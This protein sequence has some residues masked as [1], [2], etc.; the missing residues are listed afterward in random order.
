MCVC[1]HSRG[2][3]TLC[4][5]GREGV[6]VC[7]NSSCTCTCVSAHDCEGVSISTVGERC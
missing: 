7:Y 5:R 2:R 3:E 4:E 1:V 6:F